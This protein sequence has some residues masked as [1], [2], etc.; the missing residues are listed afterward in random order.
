MAFLTENVLR[1]YL[2]DAIAIYTSELALNTLTEKNNFQFLHI[3]FATGFYHFVKPKTCSLP[4]CVFKRVS[5]S[6]H[7]IPVLATFRGIKEK[8]KSLDK[9]YY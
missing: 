1:E 2:N 4:R 7:Q 3:I 5:N 8:H 9:A 6:P